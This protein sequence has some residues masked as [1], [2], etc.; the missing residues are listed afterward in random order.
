ELGM[1]E[2]DSQD[3]G[4]ITCCEG[5]TP[6]MQTHTKSFLRQKFDKQGR[7][8]WEGYGMDSIADFAYN[9]NVLLDGGKIS[10]LGDYPSGVDGIEATKIAAGVHKSLETGGIVQL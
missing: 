5:D 3:R 9:L 1:M 7:E 8:I 6:G 10:D 2:C 4:T